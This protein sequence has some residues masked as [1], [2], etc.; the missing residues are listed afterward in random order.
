LLHDRGGVESAVVEY[1]L[2]HEAVFRHFRVSGRACV[3]GSRTNRLVA[4]GNVA[5][6]WTWRASPIVA[7]IALGS[8]ARFPGPP[9]GTHF[10]DGFA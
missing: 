9:L 8:I 1:G 2:L 4:N 7:S 3:F 5:R 10:L 6:S